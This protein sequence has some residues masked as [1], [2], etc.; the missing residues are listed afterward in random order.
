M[1]PPITFRLAMFENQFDRERS[2]KILLW[3]MEALVQINILWLGEHP[4]TRSLYKSHVVY[5][6]EDNEENWQDIPTILR[7]GNGDCEDLACY[8]CAELRY[9][10]INA[11]PFVRWRK[12]AADN[13]YIYHAL[14][15]WPSGDIE[16]AAMAMGMRNG[17]MYR[18]TLFV[19][20]RNNPILKDGEE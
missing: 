6:G 9:A 18:R 12:R 14:V 2:S 15:R 8:R 13:S 7:T 19:D 10:G 20:E 4:G 16:D 3:L 1:M 17:K 11:H 5:K